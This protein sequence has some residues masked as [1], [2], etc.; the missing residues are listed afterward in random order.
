MNTQLNKLFDK[1]TNNALNGQ[2]IVDDIML[3][4]NVK[5]TEDAEKVK[6]EYKARIKKHNVGLTSEESEKILSLFNTRR[7]AMDGKERNQ[8]QSQYRLTG[9]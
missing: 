7:L 8:S 6:A 9:R 4:A 1:H 3:A 2:Q 5:T